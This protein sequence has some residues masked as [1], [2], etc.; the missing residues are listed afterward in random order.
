MKMASEKFVRLKQS[1]LLLFHL[2][3]GPPRHEH[4]KDP[5]QIEQQS[6]ESLPRTQIDHY[7]CTWEN[8]D[9]DDSGAGHNV[10]DCNLFHAAH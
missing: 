7:T 10:T 2:S 1:S 5:K 8:S 9:S 6:T 4:E 3:G